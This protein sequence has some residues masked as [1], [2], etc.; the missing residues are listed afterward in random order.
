MGIKIFVTGGTGYLG[1]RLIP[2]LLSRG[3]EVTAL[4]RTGSENKLPPG[5][6]PITGNALDETTYA[7]KVAPADTFV[8]L[9]GVSHPSP[10]KAALFESIDLTAV[11][12]SVKAATAASIKH[13]VYLSVAQP[14]PIMQAYVASRQKAEEMITKSGLNVTFVR[15]WY[16][17]GPGHRW[18]YALIPLYWIARQ[19]PS[20]RETAV[21][22]GLVTLPQMIAALLQAIENRP[23]GIR[24]IDV[25]KIQLAPKTPSL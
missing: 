17:L 9:V 5:S 3:H 24:I 13:F 20:K 4:A 10:S 18:A 23:S 21:R 1:T 12:A 19:I 16:V 2:Q 6:V 7:D 15:P 14:A 25:P 8:H 22:L 11:H